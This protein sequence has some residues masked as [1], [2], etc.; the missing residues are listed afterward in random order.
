MTGPGQIL[1]GTTISWR[2][3]GGVN[4]IVRNLSARSRSSHVWAARQHYGPSLH[5]D[6]DDG[7]P[8][9][10]LEPRRGGAKASMLAGRL[11]RRAPGIAVE[12]FGW[13]FRPAVESVGAVDA[14]VFV[15]TGVELLG[16]EFLRYARR[17]RLPFLVLPAIHPGTW[18][19]GPL[20]GRLYRSADRVFALSEH[21][22]A[23][24]ERLG[25]PSER[26]IVLRPGPTV[27]AGGDSERF[28]SRYGLGDEV[29]VGFVGR[30]TVGKR[31]DLLVAALGLLP[32]EL[33]ARLRLVVA[34]PEADAR[35]DLPPGTLDVGVPLG[36][37]KA[38]LFAA[39]D[40][41]CLPSS[42]EALGLVYLDAWSYGKPVVTGTAPGS[43]ELVRHGVDGLHADGDA[44]SVAAALR[45]LAIDRARAAAMGEA[46]RERQ[47]REYT[48]ALATEAYD[49]E[50][51]AAAAEHAPRPMSSPVR[52]REARSS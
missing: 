23:T 7:V 43:R 37:A 11:R 13:A 14:V 31:L 46:G 36:S 49:R 50:V 5:A 24:L 22:R 3:I 10:F 39:I 1:C 20:D 29:L 19:D 41:L 25:V 35:L 27:D 15:G 48:W 47:R 8:K 51:V 4:E 16:F 9:V 28:R 6:E 12:T 42:T 30:R 17:R 2:S 32:D 26:T 52:R 40:I 21:E 18:G 38:D 33:R 34:G 45:V 44:A